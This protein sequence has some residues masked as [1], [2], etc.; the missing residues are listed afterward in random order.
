[1]NKTIELNNVD[2]IINPAESFT[3]DT[4]GSD[5][6]LATITATNGASLF[7][8]LRGRELDW[9]IISGNDL[10]YFFLSTTPRDNLSTCRINNNQVNTL[11]AGVYSLLIRVTDAG[12]DFDEI[13]VTINSSVQ[14]VSINEYVYTEFNGSGNLYYFTVIEAVD[15]TNA[16]RSGFYAYLGPWSALSQ[17]LNIVL[18]YTGASKTSQCPLTSSWMFNDTFAPIPAASECATGSND[19]QYVSVNIITFTGYTFSIV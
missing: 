15:G 9:L 6:L 10:N 5:T 13:T 17:S 18:D 3:V 12:G 16:S 7:N 2:P 19:P 8:P 1:M 4:D 11:P 14:V